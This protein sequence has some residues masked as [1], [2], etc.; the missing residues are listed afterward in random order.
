MAWTS[1][2]YSN[3]HLSSFFSCFKLSVYCRFRSNPEFPSATMSAWTR[4]SRIR[5]DIGVAIVGLLGCRLAACK[6]EREHRQPHDTAVNLILSHLFSFYYCASRAGCF[7]PHELHLRDR[8]TSRTHRRN[9]ASL[10]ER[11]AETVP[12]LSIICILESV[13]C[14][15]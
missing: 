6:A 10:R 5:S 14:I 2:L 9:L 7:A 8:P 11:V 15:L 13:K 12:H 3:S 4:H 1:Y